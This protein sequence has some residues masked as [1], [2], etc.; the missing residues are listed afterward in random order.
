VSRA[1]YAVFC[2]AR[3]YA[4]I[5]YGFKPSTLPDVHKEIEIQFRKMDLYRIA[6]NLRDLRKWRNQCDYDNQVNDINSMVQKA[7]MRARE[8]FSE[9]IYS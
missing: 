9:L 2:Y 7:I 8:V 3:E 4:C 1:Y 5:K 6:N